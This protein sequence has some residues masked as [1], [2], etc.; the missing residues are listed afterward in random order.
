[1]HGD[2]S[3]ALPV[4][5]HRSKAWIGIHVTVG[6]RVMLFLI[7]NT[8]IPRS[9]LSPTVVRDLSA[10][11]LLVPTLKRGIYRLPQLSASGYALPDLTVRSQ[12]SLIPRNIEGQLGLDFFNNFEMTCFR[13][14]TS[15][16]LL[17]PLPSR[18]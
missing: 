11:N 18:G 2:A 1:M 14:S 3:F 15:E 5:L 7:L 4:L 16:L 13:R 10:L 12:P 6:E 17:E 9:T 8:A